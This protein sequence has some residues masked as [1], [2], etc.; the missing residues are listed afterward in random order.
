MAVLATLITPDTPGP[1]VLPY[2]ELVPEGLS[3]LI[4]SGRAPL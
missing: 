3:P 1:V 2:T 4:S